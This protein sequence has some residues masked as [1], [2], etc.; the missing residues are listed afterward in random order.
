MIMSKKLLFPLILLLTVRVALAGEIDYAVSKIPEALSKKANV[1]MRTDELRFE[2]VH[3]GKSITKRKYAITILN[4]SGDREA[5]LYLWYDK[6]RSIN[7]MDG[8]LYDA[9]GK[10]IRS[11]KKSEIK[12]ISAT[13]DISLADDNR[14]KVHSFYHRLYP[15]T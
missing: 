1:V 13:D 15:Y 2:V 5:F 9:A 6:L 12:D 3:L 7:S 11:L 10:K 4:E 14:V 8:N